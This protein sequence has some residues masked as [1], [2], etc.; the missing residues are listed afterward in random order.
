MKLRIFKR[1]GKSWNETKNSLK[2][3]EDHGMKLKIL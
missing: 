1:Y 3:T 2:D